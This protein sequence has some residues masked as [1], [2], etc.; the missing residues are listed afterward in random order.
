MVCRDVCLCLCLMPC[1]E[2]S[3][4]RARQQVAMRTARAPRAC[5]YPRMF[6]A[7]KKNHATVHSV[8]QAVGKGRCKGV[9]N[10]ANNM[11]AM[12]HSMSE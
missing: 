1:L 9:C 4:Q 7:S 5:E 3:T 2:S 11:S 12:K 6:Q 8:M 10:P